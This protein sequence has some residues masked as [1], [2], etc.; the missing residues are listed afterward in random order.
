MDPKKV[1]ANPNAHLAGIGQ[2]YVELTA[3]LFGGK[4]LP[5]G[6]GHIADIDHPG[7]NASLEVKGAGNT[8]GVK[9][10]DIQLQ[11][12]LEDLGGLCQQRE[13]CLYVIY[14]YISRNAQPEERITKCAPTV[15]A[16]YAELAGRT[17]TLHIVDVRLLEA[18]RRRNG[19]STD[20]RDGKQANVLTVWAWM[21]NEISADPSLITRTAGFRRGHFHIERGSIATAFR[22]HRMEF[23]VTAIVP[24]ELAPRVARSIKALR[25]VPIDFATS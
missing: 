22:R 23:P 25:Q 13:Y 17:N 11:N 10:F 21:L 24:R 5:R 12:Y 18:L 9:I 4:I 20:R 3:H 2:F 15:G 7:W 19:S 16:L 14:R 1:L 6:N 8:N